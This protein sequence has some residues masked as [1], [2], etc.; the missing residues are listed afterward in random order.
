[1]GWST[2][3]LCRN[4]HLNHH[5]PGSKPRT[6]NQSWYPC[7]VLGNYS[8]LIFW[9]LGSM[10]K[11]CIVME[12]IEWALFWGQSVKNENAHM[13]I[14]LA[15]AFGGFKSKVLSHIPEWKTCIDFFSSPHPFNRSKFIA[16]Q[17]FS[18]YISLSLFTLWPSWHC[19]SSFW[20]Q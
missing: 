10:E 1:M 16:A 18:G 15:C 8:R 12:F 17:Y 2:Q 5:H 20:A 4:H 13:G 9:D 11:S 14:C 6:C 19:A 7:F 3:F